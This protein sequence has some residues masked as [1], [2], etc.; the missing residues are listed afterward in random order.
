MPEHSKGK[1][2]RKFWR[3]KK[4]CEAYAAKH[5]RVKNNPLRTQRAEERTPHNERRNK[6][7]KGV[8][9]RSVSQHVHAS[10]ADHHRNGISPPANS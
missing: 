1:K 10:G 5:K 3:N 7:S 6:E 9:V 8:A 2:N 4:K